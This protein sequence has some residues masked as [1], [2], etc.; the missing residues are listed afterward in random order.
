[1][2]KPL[3]FVG[4]IHLGR[5]P[6]RLGA[7]GLDPTELG[8]AEAW[9]RVVRYA[10]DRKV[11]AVV[12]AGDV[13][14]HDE[15]RF[16]A[17]GHLSRGTA[18]LVEHGIRVLGVAGN[19]DHV[20]L[21]RLADRIPDFTLLG[22]DCTWQRVELEGVDLI[23]WS[24]NSRHHAGDPLESNGLQTVLDARRSDALCLGVLHGDLDQSQSRYAPVRTD[25]LAQHPV[26]GWFLGHIHQPHD[27]TQARPIGYLGSLV[28]LDRSEVGPRGPWL[29]T[30][31]SSQSLSAEQIPL[32]PAYWRAL[33]VDISHVQDGELAEDALH[34][35]IVGAMSD[36]A[37]NDPWFQAGP[38]RAVGCSIT[39][40][41]RTNARASIRQFV[42][43]WDTRHLNH[44]TGSSRWLVVALSDETRPERDLRR[45]AQQRTPL[46]QVAQLLLALD[47]GAVDAIPP[48]VSEALSGFNTANWRAAEDHHPLPD[49][50][51]VVRKAA[52]E[53]LDKLWAQRPEGL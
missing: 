18:T 17:F 38:F 24:F 47:D 44:E 13:V 33:D 9:N 16:E 6:H 52:L 27:L 1:M 26:S 34:A 39:L 36:A 19:H 2:H 45:L 3:L 35:A 8:P 12:L 46:G 53:L 37:A 23:G 7:D 10:V 25:D 5:T 28:G 11:Q 4:D 49:P 43:N 51:S 32:G 22:R 29:V 41:G 20:A 14:D 31:Q 42:Q 15:D 50:H 40:V 48:A 21:P 30:P